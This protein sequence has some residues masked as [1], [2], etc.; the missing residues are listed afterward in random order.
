MRIAVFG[1]AGF[2]G[3]HVADILSD[4][5][6]DVVIFDT[7]RSPWLRPDQEMVEGDI[8]NAE[9]VSAAIAGCEV[10]YNFAG[11]ADIGEANDRIVDSARINIIGN[12][13]VCE[14]CVTHKVRRYVF[15]STMYVYSRAGGAYRCSKQACEAYIEH[16]RSQKNL[17][18]TVLRYGSLYGPRTDNRNGIH[19]F[20]YEAVTQ[21]RIVYSGSADALREHIHVLDA[22][23]ASLEVLDPKF[24][25]QHV[26]LA[27]NQTMRMA[28][29]FRMISEIIGKDVEKVF[30]NAGASGHYET[31]PYSYAPQIGIKYAPSRHVDLGQGLLMKIEEI[32]HSHPDAVATAAQK[33]ERGRQS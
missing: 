22:A 19:R 28:D 8:L 12:L 14:A 1:G 17:E 20:V 5:G 30:L 18:Y 16:Y 21:S 32:F 2:L 15:A 7:S 13:N 26:I 24:A 29:L 31:T 25:N 33:G 10:V 27:G 4:A 23:Y 3:S 9:V 6:H 11:I